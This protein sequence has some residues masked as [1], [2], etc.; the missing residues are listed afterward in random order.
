MEQLFAAG[1]RVRAYDPAAMTE[2]GRLYGD[3]EQLELCARREH[4]LEDAD[5]LIVVTEWNE[6]RSPD[7]SYNFV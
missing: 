5:G 2:A 1:A 7:F 3:V 4:T 6:F